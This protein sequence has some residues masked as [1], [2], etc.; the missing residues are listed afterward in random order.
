MRR[1]CFV[2]RL[3]PASVRKQQKQQQQQKRPMTMLTVKFRLFHCLYSQI[4]LHF[5]SWGQTLQ[6]LL[7]TNHI[8]LG[9]CSF[10]K[11]VYPRLLGTFPWIWDLFYFNLLKSPSLYLTKEERDTVKYNRGP[12]SNILHYCCFFNANAQLVRILARKYKSVCED[13]N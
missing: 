1:H 12:Q 6:Y 3:L 11:L 13:R 4:I 2:S 8:F 7:C 9:N 5:V 10:Y